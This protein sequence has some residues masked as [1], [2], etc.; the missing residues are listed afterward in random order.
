MRILIIGGSGFI[1]SK[2]AL[3][4]KNDH[5]VSFTSHKNSLKLDG[6]KDYPLDITNKQAVIEVIKETNPEIV[7]H[8]VSQ[9]G[10][11]IYET[12]KELVDGINLIGTQNLLDA[13]KPINPLIVYISSA[14]VFDASKPIFTE[15]DEPHP[16][17]YY[18]QSKL[19]CENLVRNSGM[20]YLIARVD[21]LYGW[22]LPGQADNTVTKNIKKMEKGEQVE[23]I[24]DWYNNPTLAD[25]AA[26]VIINLITKNKRGIYHVVGS[27][28]MNR[29]EWANKTADVFN[30]DKNLIKSKNSEKL[31][32]PAKRPNAN[33]SNQKA[34]RDSRIKLLGV[35]DGLKFMRDNRI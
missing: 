19:D 12:N 33:L 7:I 1:G 28:F 24:D 8:T 17:N 21:Q 22:T 3:Q 2:L 9:K 6:C 30:L 31:N 20:E 10:T 23:E 35:E 32:L 29:V 5:Q 16:V 4:L 14:F 27:D 26:D 11:D 18:G 25:N 13:C 15:E 34:Q